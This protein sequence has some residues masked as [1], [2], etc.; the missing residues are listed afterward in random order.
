VELGQAG[1]GGI[2]DALGGGGLHSFL[3]SDLGT[4]LPLHI[5]LSRPFVLTTDEKDDFSQRLSGI[6]KEQT[7]VSR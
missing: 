6:I 5:S 2:E 3:I 1:D 4:P 7:A